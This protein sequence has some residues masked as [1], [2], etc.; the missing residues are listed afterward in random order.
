MPISQE[1]EQTHQD[2]LWRIEDSWRADREETKKLVK[3]AMIS[4]RWETDSTTKERKIA[5]YESLRKKIIWEYVEILST[6]QSQLKQLSADIR[7][8]APERKQ[9]TV[10]LPKKEEIP[11]QPKTNGSW[12]TSV[13]PE[14]VKWLAREA[15]A[16]TSDLKSLEWT[17]N[18]NVLKYLQG[19]EKSENY[20]WDPL[21]EEIKQNLL[22]S[23]DKNISDEN[24]LKVSQLFF[25]RDQNPKIRTLQE[26][27]IGNILWW[28]KW[29]NSEYIQ[30]FD[31]SDKKIGNYIM[32]VW[33]FE[34]L[35]KTS[36]N[37]WNINS[38]L[39]SNYLKYLHL[40]N[41]SI[42]EFRRTFL[43]KFWEK[44]A[45]LVT[46]WQN[47]EN[48]WWTTKIAKK[49]LA[50]S[51]FWSIVEDIVNISNYQNPTELWEKFSLIPTNVLQ[52]KLKEQWTQ[53]IEETI[54]WINT[55]IEGLNN[56]KLSISPSCKTNA[57]NFWVNNV[58]NLISFLENDGKKEMTKFLESLFVQAWVPEEKRQQLTEKF[59]ANYDSIRELLQWKDIT[60][61]KEL[62]KKIVD[63]IN[64]LFKEAW[65]NYEI[66]WEKIKN[67]AELIT[68]IRRNETGNILLQT[69]LKKEGQEVKAIQNTEAIE[70]VKRKE[71]LW[72][73]IEWEDRRARA[74]AE[75]AK[76]EAEREIITLTGKEREAATEAT[77]A[78]SQHEIVRTLSTTETIKLAEAK[79]PEERSQ[80]FWEIVQSS[81]RLQE[82]IQ[83]HDREINRINQSYG[84]TKTV[85]T[86]KDIWIKLDSS[87][88]SQ[89]KNVVQDG[90]FSINENWTYNVT[91][92]WQT[93]PW[94]TREE[95][96][97]LWNEEVRENLLH[98]YT[99]LKDCW[100]EQI[101][102]QRETIFKAIKNQK[103]IAFDTIDGNYLSKNEVRIFLQTVIRS[104]APQF[105]DQW[106]LTRA[107]NTENEQEIIS[108]IKNYN[109]ENNL[110]GP[111]KDKLGRTKITELFFDTYFLQDSDRKFQQ[112]SFESSLIS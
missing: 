13:I 67:I 16:G 76:I 103:G 99:V 110:A 109:G 96:E 47:W 30:W 23:P 7:A 19:Y 14:S 10:V 52:A 11:A 101:W 2:L 37:I 85:D 17:K 43:E 104:I 39:I 24:L 1:L 107:L 66:D 72:E 82:I 106:E 36:Q 5:A 105:K 91:I 100:L 31:A 3:D 32:K 97:W 44:W 60:T 29:Y 9:E 15:L 88:V 46:I 40:Q 41:P 63:M 79:S 49:D 22:N 87:L 20:L 84:I 98:F 62:P 81:P 80:I 56:P 70:W 74:L 94:L 34:Q 18:S 95:Y 12:L 27:Y 64:P 112:A 42:Q 6:N 86:L 83:Q 77:V 73:Q 38:L 58:E 55:V 21:Y 68:S 69:R 33:D 108:F 102:G 89:D 4:I 78:S 59:L 28:K 53:P 45:E 57:Y 71:E 25:K 93:I 50:Q 90:P 51:W 75:K 61:I 92:Q 54:R 48:S 65:V 26:K 35:L 111:A 8:I